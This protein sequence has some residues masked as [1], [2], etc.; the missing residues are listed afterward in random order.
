MMSEFRG[1]EGVP[2][3]RTFSD[4]GEVGGQGNSDIRISKSK[5]KEKLSKLSMFTVSIFVRASHAI[6][7]YS[8]MKLALTL[9]FQG[10]VS[11]YLLKKV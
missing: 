2:E 1:R 3:I 6:V 10:L 4:K 9:N 8:F 11:F 5:F 7:T